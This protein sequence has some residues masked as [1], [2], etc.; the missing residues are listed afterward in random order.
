MTDPF[1]RDGRLSAS[2]LSRLG[3]EAAGARRHVAGGAAQA[4]TAPGGMVLVPSPAAPVAWVQVTSATSQ[5][6]GMAGSRS[7]TDGGTSKGSTTLTSATANFTAADVGAA[8]GGP[9]IPAG[10]T[11]SNVTDA[12]HAVLSQAATAGGANVSVTIGPQ[13][14][15]YAGVPDDWDSATGGFDAE[16]DAVWFRPVNGEKPVGG[17][18]YQCRYLD[19]AVDGKAIWA[20][21]SFAV[22]APQ[23]YVTASS[24]VSVTP[25]TINLSTG[26]TAQGWAGTYSGGSCWLVAE[27]N[28]NAPPVAGWVYQARWNGQWDTAN[29]PLFEV[30]FDQPAGITLDPTG[31]YIAASWGGLVSAGTQTVAGNKSFTGTVTTRGNLTVG[32][33]LVTSDTG[34]ADATINGEAV[35]FEVVAVGDASG[36]SPSG[37]ARYT[38]R[39]AGGVEFGGLSGASYNSSEVAGYQG[40]LEVEAN[41]FGGPPDS[42]MVILARRN[43]DGSILGVGDQSICFDSSYIYV[44][45]AGAMT[46]CATATDPVGTMFA[47]GLAVNVNGQAVLNAGMGI[48]DYG[49]FYT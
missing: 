24:P 45:M 9:G 21:A 10:T 29:K 40:S 25:T 15:G 22:A 27:L 44:S 35:A 20:A 7:V 16:A 26:G 5:A 38:L 4:Y 3:A 41:P 11:L 17:S 19:T 30:A 6:V 28:G 8:V 18:I 32:Y 23:G 33:R 46:Q 12:S 43:L 1:T 37:L 34:F 36:Y 14:Q 2:A 39:S 47:N 49:S 13:V 42:Q 31:A 48:N